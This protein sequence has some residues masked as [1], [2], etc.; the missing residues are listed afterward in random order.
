MYGWLWH[1]LPGPW[2]V[3]VFLLA[4]AA[5]GIVAACF[6][7]FFPWVS[8][9]LPFNHVTIGDEAEPAPTVTTTVTISPSASPLDDAAPSASP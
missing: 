9:L 5:A 1:H 8:P 6:V 4:A 2:F 3:R 7:W